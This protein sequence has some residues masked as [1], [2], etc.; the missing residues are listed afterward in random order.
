MKQMKSQL[1]FLQQLYLLKRTVDSVAERAEIWSQD[2]MAPIPFG[3]RLDGSPLAQKTARQLIYWLWDT[4]ETL[5]DYVGQDLRSPIQIVKELGRE[6][7]KTPP[8]SDNLAPSASSFQSLGLEELNLAAAIFS[9]I[10][11]D[12]F[13]D[14][15]LELPC[16]HTECIPDPIIRDLRLLHGK[17]EERFHWLGEIFNDLRPEFP[18]IGDTKL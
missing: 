12:I 10:L 18:G 8:G 3:N 14:L 15:F 6:S 13:E 16:P 9:E 4:A 5:R 17:I 2:D 1:E 7:L 11:D